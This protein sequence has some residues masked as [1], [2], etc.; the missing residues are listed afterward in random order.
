MGSCDCPEKQ[1]EE[2]EWVQRTCILGC[3][4][5]LWPP[6]GSLWML[7][8]DETDETLSPWNSVSWG[9]EDSPG[10]Q[11]QLLLKAIITQNSKH[12]YIDACP[13]MLDLPRALEK[14]IWKLKAPSPFPYSH[15][16]QKSPSTLYGIPL[17]F[18][19]AHTPP[20]THKHHVPLTQKR[21]P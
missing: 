11:I 4:E 15:R 17:T 8:N 21:G 2:K 19:Q 1:V 9:S 5:L 13:H 6:L 10:T 14:C 7:S 3:L 16:N 20:H 12:R 18:L